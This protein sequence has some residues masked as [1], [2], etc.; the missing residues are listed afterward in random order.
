M[1]VDYEYFSSLYGAQAMTEAEFN[2]YSWDACKKVD[3]HTTGVDNVKKLK[4]FFPVDENDAESVKRCVC[5]LINLLHQIGMAESAAGYTVREDG[6]VQ[7]RVITSVSSGSESVNYSVG[8]TQLAKAMSDAG[9]KE[10]MLRDVII[11]HLSS[12]VDANGVNL[13]YMG[14]YPK[15]AI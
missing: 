2:R 13:L 12:V 7:G 1:Y 10:S 11:E 5:K 3:Y 14:A 4:D 15:G 8:T 9:A 6:A